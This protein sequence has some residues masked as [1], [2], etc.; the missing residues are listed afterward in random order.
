MPL[1]DARNVPWQLLASIPGRVIERRFPRDLVIIVAGT[2]SGACARPHQ[3]VGLQ[4]RRIRPPMRTGVVAAQAQRAGDA[5]GACRVSAASQKCRHILSGEGVLVPVEPLVRK[6]C[7]AHLEDIDWQ[8]ADMILI[9]NFLTAHAREP[10]EGDRR[11]LVGMGSAPERS[12]SSIPSG[13]PIDGPS[14]TWT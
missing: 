3:G 4:G 11:I 2:G 1:L 13:L 7:K 9:D 10:F 12:P 14:F 8:E 5:V 6:H